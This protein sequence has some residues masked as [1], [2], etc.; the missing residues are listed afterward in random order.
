MFIFTQAAAHFQPVHPGHIHIQDDQ[1]GQYP[2]RGFQPILAVERRLY[3]ITLAAETHLEPLD[4]VEV[5]INQKNDWLIH[6]NPL[7][8]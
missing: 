8:A 1:I 6:Q 5:V 2:A 7:Y 4:E 3:L